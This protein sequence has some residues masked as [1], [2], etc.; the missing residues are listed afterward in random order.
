[1]SALVAL[2]LAAL[3]SSPASSTPE[4]AQDFARLISAGERLEDERRAAEALSR[5]R[6]ALRVATERGDGAQQA[7]ARARACRVL[8]T[9]EATDEA[10]RECQEALTL[11]RNSAAPKAEAE[12]EKMLGTVDIHRG[13]YAAAERRFARASSIA[14]AAGETEVVISSL[15]N[16]SVAALE[17]GR[18]E[19][20]LGHSRKAWATAASFPGTSVRM[21]FAVPYNLA[22][23][24]EATGDEASARRWL[25]KAARS[26]R[27]TRFAGGLHHVLMESAR[28]L[29]TGGD[30]EGARAYYERAIEWNRGPDVQVDLALARHG[31]A[32]ALEAAGRLAEA[33]ENYRAAL[34]TLEVSGQRGFAVA[35]LIDTGR[36]LTALGL[37]EEGG[38]VLERAERLA[39]TIGL[40]VA[41]EVARLERV[42]TRRGRSATRTEQA[43]VDS[44]QRLAAMGLASH[45]AR[46][47]REAARVAER[48][49]HAPRA[50]DHLMMALAEI[51]H[52]RATLP[53]ELR[54]RF[55]ETAHA[56][57]SAVYRLRA[58]AGLAGSEAAA[59]AMFEVIERERSRDLADQSAPPHRHRRR[60][61]PLIRPSGVSRPSRRSCTAS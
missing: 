34:T 42:A 47:W 59:A 22:R 60:A 54:W 26:A 58:R 2:S 27:E 31:L 39:K 57:Y 41:E 61:P 20:A 51:E 43:Y 16:W 13:D 15:N 1:M 24:L 3:V 23:A 35:A 50:L 11:A 21:R 46:A 55:L 17:Q 37:Y 45:A 28:L 6:S 8:W 33:L 14:A 44:A 4:T 5:Y 49:G 30:Y 18:A 48:E 29:L 19:E 40:R 25:D 38:R 56:T 36:C 7:W 32:T 53:G 12:A 9:L 10:T 52:V